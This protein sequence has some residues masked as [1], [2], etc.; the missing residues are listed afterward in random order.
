MDKN[1]SVNKSN[2]LWCLR[3][4]IIS[5]SMIA[6][7]PLHHTT[8][9][10]VISLEQEVFYSLHSNMSSV[11]FTVRLWGKIIAVKEVK[12]RI[13]YFWEQERGVFEHRTLSDTRPPAWTRAGVGR[14]DDP[15][16][17]R[18]RRE[19]GRTC[20]L[21]SDW[22]HL[23]A[24]PKLLSESELA[25]AISEAELQVKIRG[26]RFRFIR[27]DAFIHSDSTEV[28]PLFISIH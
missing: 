18:G 17:V 16:A 6:V 20:E 26:C 10:L 9:S 2:L 7:I 11:L 14:T 19:V 23:A 13:S 21:R 15:S 4:K 24:V 3:R 28:I 1:V 25:A 27:T 12:S 5:F 8:L 22:F